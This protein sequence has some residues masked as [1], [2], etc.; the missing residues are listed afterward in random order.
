MTR[1]WRGLQQPVKTNITTEHI[2]KYTQRPDHG[3]G[4]GN[5]LKQT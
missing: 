4:C 5:L 1:S 2:G 3:E